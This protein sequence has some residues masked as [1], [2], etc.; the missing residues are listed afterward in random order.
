MLPDPPSSTRTNASRA[1]SLPLSQSQIELASRI[2]GAAVHQPLYAAYRPD[3]QR[4][5]AP[6]I[7]PKPPV[8]L[9]KPSCRFPFNLEAGSEACERAKTNAKATNGH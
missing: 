3:P 8:A 4:L 6:G 1:Y 2:D 5:A 9:F 7:D